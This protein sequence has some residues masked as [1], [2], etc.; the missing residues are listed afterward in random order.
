MSFEPDN[1]ES[2]SER[3]SKSARPVKAEDIAAEILR[4]AGDSSV[5]SIYRSRVISQRTRQ[6]ELNSP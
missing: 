6:Y 4:Q 1:I 2:I 5:S 3:L